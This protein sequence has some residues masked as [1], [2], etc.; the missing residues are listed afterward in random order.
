[1]SKRYNLY[2]GKSG[3]FAIMAEFLARGWNTCTPD[4]D[5]G[6]DVLVLEDRAGQF[7]R[8]Q[9]KTA[10]AVE[11]NNGY[12]A[13]FNIPL[14]QLSLPISPEIH[15]VFMVRYKNKWINTLIIKR[16]YLDKM[17]N[18]KPYAE[19]KKNWVM[20]IS[21]QGNDIKCFNVDFAQFV[22]DFSEFPDISH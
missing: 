20:Y 4:V 13:Q 1:M 12:S 7:K 11:R 16:D 9:V 19:V 2:L 21:F 5:V 8:V 17:Y 3:Q 14:E 15:Y 6:D 22:D 10:S 18:S